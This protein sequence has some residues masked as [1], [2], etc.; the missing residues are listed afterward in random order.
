MMRRAMCALVVAAT[1]VVATTASAQGEDQRPYAGLDLGASVPVTDHYWSH[2]HLGGAASPYVGYMFHRNFGLQLNGHVA[3]QPPDDDGRG[4]PNE[5]D[6][7]TVLGLTAGP[8][9]SLPL[10]DR[11]ELYGLGQG[12]FYSGVSGRL[13]DT[14]FG[15][16]AG[17][18]MDV[19][20]TRNVALSAFGRW[21]YSF[22]QPEPSRLGPPYTGGATQNPEDQGPEDIQWVTA[23]IGIKYDFRHE[24]PPPPPPPVVVVEAPPP[25]EPKL[26]PPTKRK[27]VLRSVHFDF[28][29]ATIRSDAKPIL[30]QA[31][32]TLREEGAVSVVIEGH[33]DSVGPEKYNMELGRRRAA[34]VREALSS[35]GI[36]RSRIEIVSYGESRPVATNDTDEGRQ[37][38][39]RVELDVR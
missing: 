28:D 27:I 1:M 24:P 3:L 26:P 31:A 30:D 21:H 34:A 38:N 10:G 29:K 9:L 4:I 37:Q 6:V 19:Y 22:L 39:R 5:G 35:R 33:T 25:P 32:R 36:D 18:G 15:F 12:G 14:E 16:A 7:T 23:G 17:A 8:R 11:V 20:L 13:D 2:V